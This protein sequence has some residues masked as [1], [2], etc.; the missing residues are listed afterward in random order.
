[1]TL[2]S[3]LKEDAGDQSTEILTATNRI[4]WIS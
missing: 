1:M 4:R 3:T 2:T